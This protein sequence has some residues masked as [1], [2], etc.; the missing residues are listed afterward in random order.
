MNKINRAG[1]PT[2]VARQLVSLG[3]L[4]AARESFTYDNNFM[5]S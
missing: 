1:E 2:I 5:G 4:H 3:I